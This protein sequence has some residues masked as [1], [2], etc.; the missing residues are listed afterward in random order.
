MFHKLKQVARFFR[1]SAQSMVGVP[2]YDNYVALM[3]VKSP[4]EP[5]MSYEAFFRERQEARF[6][7]GK[8]NTRCC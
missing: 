1:Q 6:G 3:A 7:R 2:D 8:C 5:V 4:G